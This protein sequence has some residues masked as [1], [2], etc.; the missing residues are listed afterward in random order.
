MGGFQW[1]TYQRQYASAFFKKLGGRYKRIRLRPKGKPLPEVYDYKLEQ[2]KSL[3]QLSEQGHIDLFYGDES[4]VCTQGYVPYG[5]QFPDEEVCIASQ[6]AK[7]LNCLGFINRHSECFSVTTDQNIGAQFVAEYLEEFSFKI[8]RQTV[9]ILDNA[10]VHKSHIIKER[11]AYWQHRGLFIV[12]LP[13]Y[14]P[15]LNIAETLWRKLKKEWLNPEDYFDSEALFY[16]VNRCLANVGKELGIKF[17]QF[18]I[19]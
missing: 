12:Y 5:W 19:N 17:K 10:S 7:R 3:E 13:P 4:H 2:I 18:S 14:C 11:I 6:K 1:Q 16:A 8:H 15:H 9:I